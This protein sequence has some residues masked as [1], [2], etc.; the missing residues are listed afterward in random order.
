M[1]LEL[2]RTELSGYDTIADTTLFSEETLECIVP[3]ACPDILRILDT[4]GVV[5]V[6]SK[7]AGEGRAEL[8][9]MI[10]ACVLYLP[11]GA[12]GIRT[13]EVS[14]P[15]TCGTDHPAI[16]TG[17]I[18]HA[19]PRL[20]SAD[21]RMLNPRKVYVRAEIAVGFQLFSPSAAMVSTSCDCQ[22]S[23][24]IQEKR[25]RCQTYRIAAVQE[26]PFTFSDDLALPGSKPDLAELLRQRVDLSCTESKV[27]GNKL[28]FKGQ[29][30][31]T[32]LYRTEDL[33]PVTVSFELPFSQIMEVSGA[34][35]EADCD[36]ELTLND[37]SCQ[38]DPEDHRTI[39]V[40]MGL[41]AQTVLR[42]EHSVEVVSD[43]YSTAYE[44]TVERQEDTF[45]R[46]SE[47]GSRRQSFRE[48][49]ETSVAVKSVVDCSL[50]IGA[51]SQSWEGNLLTM[52]ADT[53]VMI[54]YRG[55]DDELYSLV[56]PVPVS[57]QWEP[58]AGCSCFCRCSC[59]GEFYATPTVG[60]IEVRFP[61]DFHYRA[62]TRHT[63][64][65]AAAA[66]LDEERLCDSTQRPSI[67]LRMVEEG[68]TL[69]DIAKAYATTSADIIGANELTEE[70]VPMGRLLL[71]PKKR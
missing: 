14:I 66:H 19:V 70:A 65:E 5:C 58:E 68:E 25:E 57:C 40:S 42:E 18:V 48:I 62:E 8:R 56:R 11:D 60:G 38:P 1:E 27:I 44:L 36:L 33:M 3:D 46:L 43:L 50:A 4:D 22:E 7:E 41:L 2:N 55:E 29:A 67:V 35:E 47:R 20:L 30:V 59:P 31:L 24:G 53:R 49:L 52:S 63:V 64:L 32:L 15:F 51:V 26:K 12:E 69:W 6:K 9:G 10:R 39:S 71:I 17:C 13:M 28:I 16:H 21:A 23:W 54:L 37:I 34:A 45:G 61:L